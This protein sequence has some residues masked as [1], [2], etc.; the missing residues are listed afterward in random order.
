MTNQTTPEFTGTVTAGA[1]AEIYEYEYDTV[2]VLTT[3]SYASF[4]LTIAPEWLL[5]LL[6]LQPGQLGEWE[7]RGL[8]RCVVFLVPSDPGGD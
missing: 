4:A 5:Q 3:S 7:L 2:R 8:C 6:V 1:T